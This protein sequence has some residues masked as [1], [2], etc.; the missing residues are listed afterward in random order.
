MS[1]KY[2]KLY[3]N[4]RLNYL[5]STIT[6]KTPLISLIDRFDFFFYVRPSNGVNP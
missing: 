4:S 1:T 2:F 5:F 3:L 6:T